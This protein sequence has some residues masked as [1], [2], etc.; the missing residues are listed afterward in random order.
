M[1]NLGILKIFF[2]IVCK[3]NFVNGKHDC[4]SNPYLPLPKNTGVYPQNYNADLVAR[5]INNWR[6]GDKH[7]VEEYTNLFDGDIMLTEEQLLL[8]TIPKSNLWH[9]GEMPFY[10]TMEQFTERQIAHIISTMDIITN[11]TGFKFRRF[12]FETDRNYAVFKSANTGCWSYVGML[13]Y[14]QVINLQIPNCLYRGTVIHVLLHAIGFYHEHNSPVRDNWLSVKWENILSTNK[15]YFKT[16][17]SITARDSGV[18]YDYD[19]ILHGGPYLHSFN[20]KPTMETQIPNMKIGQR[21]AFSL[22]DVER[23]RRVYEDEVKNWK[24]LDKLP[25]IN[26][27][28][29]TTGFISTDDI[30]S[31][32]ASGITAKMND[33][34]EP[35]SDDKRKET[36]DMDKTERDEEKLT[37]DETEHE[38]VMR[39]TTT[40][41]DKRILNVFCLIWPYTINE[42][43]LT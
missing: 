37:T 2:L 3:S 14:G 7:N 35:T 5:R 21:E 20:D 4:Y 6:R 27:T 17:D 9:R 16:L 29:K 19:S 32:T 22:R 15:N 18:L 8:D 34:E 12:C 42:T 41:A 40:A 26:H 30:A 25:K 10:I 31:T 13:N 23:V 33:T 11:H 36:T 24:S 39:S 43:C 1:A 38:T 28:R